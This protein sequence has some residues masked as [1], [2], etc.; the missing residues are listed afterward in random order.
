MFSN[1]F[2]PSGFQMVKTHLAKYTIKLYKGEIIH[3][4]SYILSRKDSNWLSVSFGEAPEVN[5]H[6][7]LNYFQIIIL[8]IF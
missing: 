7:N 1:L 4:D 2:I 5:L 3:T 6:L 8:K